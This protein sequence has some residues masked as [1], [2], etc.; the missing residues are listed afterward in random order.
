MRIAMVGVRGIPARMGG[1]ERVVEELSRE[2]AARGH[3]VIVYCRRYYVAGSQAPEFA[4]TIV[5]PHLGGK[6]LETI[7]HTAASMVDL[8][9]RN[10]DLVH[11][12]SPG[13]GMMSW[14]AGLAGLPTV[15][16]IHAPDWRRDKWPAPAKGALRLGLWCGMHLANEVTA[17]GRALAEELSARF[18]REVHH[19]PNGVRPAELRPPSAIARWGLADGRYVL[20]VGRVVPE[21]RLDLLLAAWGEAGGKGGTRLVVVG[22][23]DSSSYGRG[24]RA[25]AAGDVLLLPPQYGAVLEELYSNALFVVQPSSLEGMSMVLLEAAAHRRC[26]LATDIEANLDMM[27]DCIL[28]FH[29]EDKT[30]LNRQLSLLLNSEEMR[31][32]LAQRA[33]SKVL[34]EYTWPAAAD[35]MEQ[36][37]RRAILTA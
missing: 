31:N 22:D 37:Y 32:Q 35:R 36:V 3:E 11:I 5:T 1:A 28:Y 13:P 8:L 21:K 9:R 30:D 12:H 34:S 33:A 19:V 10:V 26:I 25:A 24:C 16:T 15:L 23:L 18:G 29:S 7:T 27:G 14:L 17:V 20:T 6:Y 2:L 4:R